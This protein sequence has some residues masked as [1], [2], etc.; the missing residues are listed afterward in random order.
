MTDKFF[1]QTAAI[2]DAQNL[3]VNPDKERGYVLVRPQ[4]IGQWSAPGSPRSVTEARVA[5][6]YTNTPAG[7]RL[8]EQQ[9]M[10]HALE[11]QAAY[12]QP[13]DNPATTS[14]L[15]TVPLSN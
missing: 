12:A 3:N 8:W 10:A 5:K 2:L 14:T 11:L 13:V 4:E 7:H 9:A 6:R 15:I 1:K